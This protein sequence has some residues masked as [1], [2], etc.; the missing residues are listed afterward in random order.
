MGHEELDVRRVVAVAL[1]LRSCHPEQ[2]RTPVA[3][4]SKREARNKGSPVRKHWAEEKKTM[5]AVGAAHHPNT[6]CGSNS[7]P[8]F[9]NKASSSS[10]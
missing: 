1:P 5:S 3:S 10:S 6:N 9:L 2:A 4:R 8:C 7:I